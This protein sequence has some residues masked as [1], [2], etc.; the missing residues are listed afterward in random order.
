MAIVV[1]DD[2]DDVRNAIRAILE[3]EGH[4]TIGVCTG[5]E[6]L[7]LL[8]HSEHRPSLILLD[9][10]M[11]EWMGGRSCLASTS[12]ADLHSIPVA[13]MSAHPSVRKA[14]EKS[15]ASDESRRLLFPKPAQRSAASVAR[16]TSL[17]S[18]RSTVLSS[19]SRARAATM[20]A[21]RVRI[22]DARQIAS[23]AGNSVGR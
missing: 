15:K 9:L 12:Q 8:E 3:D 14:F 23:R 1:V 19:C 4:R 16:R 5:E 17:R 6:A 22:D 13:L 20:A 11:P 7:F 10:M 18:A 21:P 2:D